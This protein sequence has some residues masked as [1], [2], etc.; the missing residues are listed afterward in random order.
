MS[1]LVLGTGETADALRDALGRRGLREAAGTPAAIVCAQSDLLRAFAMRDSSPAA[2]PLVVVLTEDPVAAIEAGADDAGKEPDEVAQR[3]EVRLKIATSAVHKALG[4]SV[5]DDPAKAPLVSTKRRRPPLIF[6]VDDDEDARDLLEELL[7]DRYDVETFGDGETA[8]K[9]AKELLPDLVLLDL[10]LPG[11]DGFAVLTALRRDLTT[12]D[13]PVIFLSAQGDAETKSQGLD[14]GAD[15]YLAKPFDVQELLARVERRLKVAAEKEHFRALAGMDGLTGLPNRRSFE[16]RLE[17]EIARVHRYK[18]PLALAMI[19]LDGLKKINDGRG[20]AAGDRAILA[21]ADALR[22]VRRE[23]DFAARWAGDEFAMLLPQTSAQ[24]AELFAERLR[25]R[26]L[27]VS[28]ETGLSVRASIGVAELSP[29]SE[30]VGEEAA[31]DLLRRADEKLYK[32]KRSVRKRRVAHPTPHQSVAAVLFWL[33]HSVAAVLFWL[34]A[35]LSSR[36]RR[37]RQVVAV[38]GT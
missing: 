28:D 3:V 26:L 25:L 8:V 24:A 32:E 36:A 4:T 1:V 2:R 15:D 19:D 23:N 14:R 38:A 20:H 34:A 17:E 7:R 11:E 6:V 29:T 35:R 13:V 37:H 18:H 30:I 21:L 10:F 5:E 9:R 12:A 22:E 31:A 27:K 33:D 16:A